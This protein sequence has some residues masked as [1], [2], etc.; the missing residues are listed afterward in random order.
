MDEATKE[1]FKW[2]FYRL[3]VLANLAILFVAIGFIAL[4]KAPEDYSLPLAAGLFIMAGL[5]IV[6][7]RGQYKV[8]KSWLDENQ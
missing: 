4:F 2:K 6:Y 7:F 3:A 5:L 1:R 8:T